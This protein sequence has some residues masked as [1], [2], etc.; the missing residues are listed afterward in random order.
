MVSNGYLIMGGGTTDDVT[1][2]NQVFPDAVAPNNV[3]A[4]FW[5]DLNPDAG[6]EL[7]ASIL[8]DPLSGLSWVVFEWTNV[9]NYDDGELNTFQVWMGINGTHD[10]S[11]VY[12][13]VSDGNN[14]FV[15]VGA[16]NSFGNS[17]GNWFVNGVGNA[18]TTGDEV[19][20]TAIPGAP[21]ESHSI[22]FEVTGWAVGDWSNCVELT[23]DLF[24]GT[25]V[26]CFSGEI[27]EATS[28]NP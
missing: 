11:F 17:G 20:I 18:V 26:V 13:N 9:P 3:I 6:G 2:L 1:Y 15:T 27:T 4:P 19:M 16:E 22:E 23:S 28:W 5:T 12:G 10:V 25:N 14:G 8:T 21:G 24:E 7:Y